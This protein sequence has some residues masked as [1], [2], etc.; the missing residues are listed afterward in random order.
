MA[1]FD[2]NPMA[3]TLAETAMT[4]TMNA[5]LAALQAEMLG[6]RMVMPCHETP[7]Q[8]EARHRAEEAA[9]EEA[10]DNMPV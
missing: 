2:T 4:A 6:L 7:P 1:R 3:K 10:F 5:T 9:A 8:T